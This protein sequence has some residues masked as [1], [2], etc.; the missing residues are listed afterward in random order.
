MKKLFLLPLLCLSINT[1]SQS[2]TIYG[3]DNRKDLY[4]V[5]NPLHQKLA[6]SVAALFYNG[7]L[8]V[9]DEGNFNIQNYF[10]HRGNALNLCEGERFREQQM[11]GFCTGFLVGPDLV[12]TAG[13]CIYDETDCSWSS[14][15]FDFAL[16]REHTAIE[17]VK[18][19]NV[20]RC[21]EVVK[22]SFSPF[23]GHVADYSVIRLDRKVVDREILKVNPNPIDPGAKLLVIGHPD[24]M[25]MKVADQAYVRKVKKHSK[26]FVTNTDSYGGNSGSPVFNEMTGMVEGIL[27]RGPADYIEKN[28]CR[29]SKIC[30]MDGCSGELVTKGQLILPAVLP[31][32]IPL[33]H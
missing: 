29:V 24:G 10:S 8:N 14:V 23:W 20:Y 9:N 30:A 21:K 18:K 7:R 1:F 17:H 15:V 27:V 33:A 31:H 25:P 32:L 12:A 3:E 22:M 19:E 16:E 26:F 2:K 6:K 13:H 5:T 11:T 28:G 4:Q